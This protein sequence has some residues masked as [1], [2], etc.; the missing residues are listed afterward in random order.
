MSSEIRKQVFDFIV[1]LLFSISF[2]LYSGCQDSEQN[3]FKSFEKNE[4]GEL[5]E[6]NQLWSVDLPYETSGQVTLDI[7][8]NGEL[9]ITESN[10]GFHLTKIVS[11]SGTMVDQPL[12]L[13]LEHGT[14]HEWLDETHLLVTEDDDKSGNKYIYLIDYTNF[15]PKQTKIIR[16]GKRGDFVIPGRKRHDDKIIFYN[17]DF[18][19]DRYDKYV[20]NMHYRI[21][22][23]KSVRYNFYIWSIE[24]NSL[25]TFEKIS[26]NSL[27][28]LD[29]ISMMSYSNA[30]EEDSKS[31][32]NYLFYVDNVFLVNQNQTMIFTLATPAKISMH[33]SLDLNQGISSI[34]QHTAE[35]LASLYKSEL[36]VK[37]AKQEN[38]D[39]S[40]QSGDL[41]ISGIAYEI[42]NMAIFSDIII[43]LGRKVQDKFLK[44]TYVL[45][46][47]GEMKEK[48][49][50]KIETSYNV[51]TLITDKVNNI[52]YVPDQSSNRKLFLRGFQVEN[53]AIQPG[54]PANFIVQ[55]KNDMRFLS[56][57]CTKFDFKNERVYI[58]DRNNSRIIFAKL[59]KRIIRYSH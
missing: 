12:H 29:G 10:Q 21:P 13:K 16:T 41:V 22:Y 8:K 31:L 35:E 37:V 47:D 55:K 7:V 18:K 11:D 33:Y 14:S 45:G 4:R 49:S 2:L 20:G 30:I 54:I 51:N 6:R 26:E 42:D 58:Y 17:A 34:K 27:G 50:Y 23:I 39:K 36:T 9:L 59:P 56:V 38:E 32:E 40:P 15:E 57:S 24:D 44:P 53:G 3:L 19:I 25:L 48:W 5:I 1:L 43:L 28:T 52:V 46:V